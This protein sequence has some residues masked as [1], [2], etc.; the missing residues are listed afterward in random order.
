MHLPYMQVRCQWL[1]VTHN[2]LLGVRLVLDNTNDKYTDTHRD[3]QG[4][5]RLGSVRLG[6]C[7]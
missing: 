1:D 3:V 5:V 7:I 4:W 6:Q 2:E